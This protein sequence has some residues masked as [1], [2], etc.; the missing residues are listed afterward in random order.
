VPV[1]TAQ[2]QNKAPRLGDT[3]TFDVS[4]TGT[5][6]LTY[7]WQ[8][9]EYPGGA[10]ADIGGATSS[11]YT[12]GAITSTDQRDQYRCN[13]TDTIGTTTSD[14]ATLTIGAHDT[15]LFERPDE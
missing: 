4:A 15:F 8:K 7:Q 6:G 3:A 2:P 14:A 13:I 9:S 12:T 10:F 5:G 1:I 11:G